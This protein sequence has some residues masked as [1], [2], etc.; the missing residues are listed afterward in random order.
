MAALAEARL[1][2]ALLPFRAWRETLGCPAGTANE[3][4]V[5]LWASHVEWA[6][7]RLPIAMK[8]LPQAM[9]LSRILRRKKIRHVLVFAV[10][11]Q[12]VRGDDDA[13]HAWVEI[14]GRVYIGHLPGPWIETLRQGA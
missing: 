10:R 1:K 9:A 11:P 4:Q 12:H 13:L 5:I 7:R 3:G 2:I 6:A 8:C 14:D